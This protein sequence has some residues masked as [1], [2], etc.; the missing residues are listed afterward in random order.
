MREWKVFTL[1]LLPLVRLFSEEKLNNTCEE[2][3]I[4]V[5]NIFYSLKNY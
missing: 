4:L 1:V 3:E 5:Q 2:K